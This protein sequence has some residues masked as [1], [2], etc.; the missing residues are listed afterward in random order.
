M[1]STTRTRLAFTLAYLLLLPFHAGAADLP[2]T[3][4][5]VARIKVRELV[6]LMG[7]EPVVIVDARIP[8]AWKR[9]G[10]KVPGAIRLSTPEQI[11]RFAETTSRRQTIV[12]YCL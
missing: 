1:F 7:E 11:A 4:D 9:A 5:Q 12:L 10:N 2:Q 6:Q 3:S 8:R